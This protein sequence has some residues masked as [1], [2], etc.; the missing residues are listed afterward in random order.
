MLD[1]RNFLYNNLG[2]L[3]PIIS[4]LLSVPIFLELFGQ[5]RY[6]VLIIFWLIT[7]Y[8]GIFDLGL[9]SA[10]TILLSRASAS[11][12]VIKQKYIEAGI[13]ISFC[14]G[15]LSTVVLMLSINQTT[16]EVIGIPLELYSEFRY[17]IFLLLIIVPLSTMGSILC[18]AHAAKENFK[19]INLSN[20]MLTVFYQWMPIIACTIYP[21]SISTIIF[22]ATIAKI[23]QFCFLL[24]GI[25]NLSFQLWKIRPNVR[26]VKVL[27]GIGGWLS[28]SKICAPL[29][30]AADRYVISGTLGVALVASY[31]LP[32][33][34]AEKIALFAT[35]ITTLIVP[36]LSKKEGA[37]KVRVSV[38]SQYIMA[39]LSIS[40]NFVGC[41][42]I[43]P[44]L[45]YWVGEHV[46]INFGIVPS[47]LILGFSMNILAY[48]PFTHMQTNG[49]GKV[50]ALIHLLELPVY[51][52]FS[53]VFTVKFGITG[54]AIIFV[55]RI[56]VDTLLMCFYSRVAI[57]R[58]ATLYLPIICNIIIFSFTSLDLPIFYEYA[59]IFLIVI[60][61]I[62]LCKRTFFTLAHNSR[63]THMKN[64]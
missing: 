42:L 28:I 9:G 1:I 22:S 26:E 21:P 56:L 48:V 52:V 50:A 23:I 44:F 51:I 14:I 3:F 8:L 34:I 63:L 25:N 15:L 36:K 41:L 6:G 29:I 54:M 31:N 49:R 16:V 61:S 4:T 13:L 37:Y 53:I 12:A 57:D 18:G 11:R 55:I 7:G 32:Y 30:S 47:F 40:S 17:S 62:F 38:I 10:V 43:Y 45:N 27:L 60:Y 46:Q 2:V 20:I 5:D 33:Q 59:S 39:W 58:I 24:K 35:T 64:R 19:I